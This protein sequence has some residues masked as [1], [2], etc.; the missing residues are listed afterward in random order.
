[1]EESLQVSGSNTVAIHLPGTMDR[2]I[3]LYK[4]TIQ[5]NV[6][7]NTECKFTNSDV[8]LMHVCSGRTATSTF[9]AMYVA[10]SQSK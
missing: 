7:N 9:L 1:M 5:S 2:R 4:Y 10:L 8:V 6:I 3:Y